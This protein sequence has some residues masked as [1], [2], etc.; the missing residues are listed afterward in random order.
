MPSL[1]PTP[2]AGSAVSLVRSVAIITGVAA[3][4]LTTVGWASPTG[5]GEQAGPAT[6]ASWADLR[7][8]ANRDGNVDLTGDSDT[9]GGLK[10]VTELRAGALFLPNL[11]DDARRCPLKNA[12]RKA[13]PIQVRARCH[14]GADTVVNGP[15]DALDLALI[16]TVPNAQIPDS[17][18]A[19]VAVLGRA[20]PRRTHLFRQTPTGWRL[21]RSGD[22][23]TAAELRAGLTFG[24]EAT[25]IVRDPSVWDGRAYIRLTVTAAG[26]THQDIIALRQAP[27]L[28]QDTTA[29]LDKLFI[30]ATEGGEN[31][32]TTKPLAR[33][34]K[35]EKIPFAPVAGSV[36]D[37]WLQDMYE[38]ALVSMPGPNG[39]TRS[40]RILLLSDQNER[41]ADIYAMRGPGVGVLWQGP[42]T[43]DN[44]LDATGNVETLPAYRNA[45]TR[46]PLGRVI[47]GYSPAQEAMGALMPSARFRK[48]LTA[49]TGI[50]PLLINTGWLS[51]GHVDEFLQVLPAKNG[52]RWKL[53]VADPVGAW[54]LIER[55]VAGGAGKIPA[56]SHRNAFD[57]RSLAEVTKDRALRKANE[58]AG[59]RIAATIAQLKNETGITDAD[60]VKI[61]VLFREQP[62]NGEDPSN[63]EYPNR[64]AA[65]KPK[66]VAKGALN[67]M[68][69]FLPDAVNGVVIDA[70]RVLVPQQFGPVVGGRDLFADAVSAA[71][72][73]VGVRAIFIDTYDSYHTGGGEI[74]CGT[75]AFRT[76]LTPWWKMTS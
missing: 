43:I 53:A 55:A 13:L 48:M 27:V 70:D 62:N 45:T 4:L 17:A 47:I 1:L 39:T 52:G 54:Q 26:T 34:A 18:T 11:D 40:M 9:A 37:T 38:P 30:T 33:I 69:A 22:T 29:T 21:H 3:G 67:T 71:Y 19:T 61:P 51:V 41:G 32:A 63:P 74:H 58:Y 68:S 25:D 28:S 66:P 2:R 20:A 75:N 6:T 42:T 57:K 35:A 56:A 59:T 7:A 5:R 49:Q 44:T 36:M 10:T 8:D 23:I 73:S 46:H 16:K 64:P 14:D 50:A 15:A 65:P 31:A 60:I 72:A 24:L 76:P 12:K